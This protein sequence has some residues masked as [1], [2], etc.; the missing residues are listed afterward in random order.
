[1][2][3]QN[4]ACKLVNYINEHKT[5]IKSNEPPKTL[6]QNKTTTIN[7]KFNQT[8]TKLKLNQISCDNG[9][10]QSNRPWQSSNSVEGNMVE[11]KSNQWPTRAQIQLN[12]LW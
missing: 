7:F 2:E 9:E 1:M 5:H 12:Y 3:K 10:V 6:N 4:I 11:L 8:T